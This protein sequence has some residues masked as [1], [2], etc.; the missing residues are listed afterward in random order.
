MPS[1]PEEKF[2]DKLPDRPLE[3]SECKKAIAVHYTEIVGESTIHT[4]MCADCPELQRRLHGTPQ[5]L[6]GNAAEGGTGLACG[7]CGTTLDALR[8]GMPL[9]CSDCYQVFEDVL[10]AELL[11][12]GKVPN[13]LS[14]NRKTMPFHIGRSPGEVVEI[15][16]SLR[17]LALNEALNETLKREDYEQAAWLRDQIKALTD[18]QEKKDG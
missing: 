10:L 1:K 7:N 3:C 8:V 12:S 18:N 15:N 4:C 11:S 2:F 5:P 16:P 17:L 6:T 13:R 9:G 14:N